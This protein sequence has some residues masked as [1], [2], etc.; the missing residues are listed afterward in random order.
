MLSAFKLAAHHMIEGNL[1]QHLTKALRLP[2]AFGR[3]RRWRVAA[4][5][6]RYVGFGFAVAD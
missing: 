3:E 2:L 6:A 4:V 5:Q 1:L